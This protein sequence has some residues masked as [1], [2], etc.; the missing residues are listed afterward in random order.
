MRKP[1]LR[2]AVCH[3]AVRGKSSSIQFSKRFITRAGHFAGDS[4]SIDTGHGMFKSSSTSA[5]LIIATGIGHPEWGKASAVHCSTRFF[6][7]PVLM[8]SLI[9]SAPACSNLRPRSSTDSQLDCSSMRTDTFPLLEAL[10]SA[11]NPQ[12][13]ALTLT[14]VK[15]VPWRARRFRLRRSILQSPGCWTRRPACLR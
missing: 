1:S 13:P 11:S 8:K 2:A 10:T 3:I 4:N 15:L 14:T 12:A 6:F 7:S 9:V 5:A